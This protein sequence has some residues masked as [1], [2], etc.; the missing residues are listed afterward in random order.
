MPRTFPELMRLANAFAESQTLLAA[1]DLGIF[2]AIGGGSRTAKQVARR[3]RTDAEGTRLLLDALVSLGLL[4]PRERGYRNTPLGRHYLDNSSAQAITN[5]LWLLSQHWHDW[6]KLPESLR[7]GRPHRPSNRASRAFQRRFALAMHERSHY[8]AA[9]TVS[10]IRLPPKSNWFLDLGGGPGSYAIALAKR[11]PRLKGVVM[12]QNVAIARQ[13]IRQAGLET[14]LKVKAGSIF[15]DALGSGYDAVL[16][17]NVLHVFGEEE[18]RRL[19]RRIRTAMKPGGKVFVVEFFLDATR[20]SPAKSAVFSVLMY[21]F[22]ATGRC[23]SWREVES[24]LK[25][26]GFAKFKR[27]RITPD[28]GIL[29][30]TKLFPLLT[31]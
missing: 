18:N 20:T 13:L 10:A 21:L 1:N 3:C 16:I 12:D 11:H 31:H 23:Y 6:T 27:H 19:L 7:K 25:K 26:L 4:R 24:W 2:A 22:T 30:A 29:E 14:R 28:I 17:S 9:P 8:L 15:T 5:L